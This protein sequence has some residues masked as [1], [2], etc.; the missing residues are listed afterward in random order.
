MCAGGVRQDSAS[1][2]DTLPS[3]G[4]TSALEGLGA[5]D[6]QTI[7]EQDRKQYA[8]KE[9]EILAENIMLAI[10]DYQ[11]EEHVVG[12]RWCNKDV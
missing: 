2:A 5:Q 4:D 10:A 11:A 8:V 12:T 1:V 3:V 9:T 6:L 7:E